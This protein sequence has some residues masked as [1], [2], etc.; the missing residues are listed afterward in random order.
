MDHK[1]ENR[2][3]ASL[4]EFAKHLAVALRE[5]YPT[6]SLKRERF[7]QQELTSYYCTAVAAAAEQMQL[8][9]VPEW[10]RFD[11]ALMNNTDVVALA[12]WE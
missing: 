6:E 9:A 10:R 2:A 8:H 4:A 3:R 1:T 11:A 5:R 12:E 7:S